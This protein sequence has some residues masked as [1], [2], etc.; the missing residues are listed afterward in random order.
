MEEKSSRSQD[1]SAGVLHAYLVGLKKHLY[2]NN[3]EAAKVLGIHRI[4]T[5]S[6]ITDL[7][8]ELASC[9]KVNNQPAGTITVTLET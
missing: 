2:V 5:T 3:E 4:I 6:N 8:T 1:V 9:Q 7:E